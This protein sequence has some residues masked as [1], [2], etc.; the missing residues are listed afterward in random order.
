MHSKLKQHLA[1]ATGAVSAA[2][3]PIGADA[4]IVYKDSNNAFSV[5]YD[6][7]LSAEWDIDGAS[8]SDFRLWAIFSYPLYFLDFD[9]GNRNGR[10]FAG[11]GTYR[12]NF[13]NLPAGAA[14][15]GASIGPTLAGYNWNGTGNG[16]RTVMF[17]ANPAQSFQNAV[18]GSNYVGFR[19]LSG[20]DM[21]YGWAELILATTGG[22]TVTVNRWAYNDTPNGSIKVGQT[23]DASD[24][25]P[26]PTPIPAPSTLALL[27]AGAFGLRR[28][29]TQRAAA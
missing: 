4:A 14:S 19:F 18:L 15:A 16:G 11:P 24:P 28:W 25:D 22:G 5:S 29:R 6:G 12:R 7:P 20:T 21:L 17:G 10:G 2:T 9:S 1:I 8:G 27:A 3:V 23:E 13:A 26:D